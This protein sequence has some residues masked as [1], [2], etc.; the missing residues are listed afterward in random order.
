VRDAAGAVVIAADYSELR[1]L[2]IT[3]TVIGL[4]L[5]LAAIVLVKLTPLIGV[6]DTKGTK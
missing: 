6:G 1:K 4:V 3:V 2:L 5:P